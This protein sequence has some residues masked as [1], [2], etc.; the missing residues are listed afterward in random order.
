MRAGRLRARVTIQERGLS[1]NELGEA[2]ADWSTV[3][4]VPA[5]VRMASGDERF[6]G[7]GDVEQASITHVVRMRYRSDVTP[8]E[9]LLHGERV[10]DIVSAV[11]PDGRRRELVLRCVERLAA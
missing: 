2:L 3:A 8:L 6:V 9:R 5:D 10:L 11:D 1:R 7:G 4:T